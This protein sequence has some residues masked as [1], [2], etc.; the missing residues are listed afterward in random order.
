MFTFDDLIKLDSAGVQT[1]MR[2]VEKDKMT[3][4]SRAGR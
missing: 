2:I 1:L 4:G 3:M